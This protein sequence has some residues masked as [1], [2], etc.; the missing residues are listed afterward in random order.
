MQKLYELDEK[1]FLLK[2][3]EAAKEILPVLLSQHPPEYVIDVKKRSSVIYNCVS[4]A[5]DLLNEVG[6]IVKG[7]SKAVPEEDR[8]A[9]RKLED[10][11]KEDQK[12]K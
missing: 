3:L 8:T 12:K 10:I 6:F 1:E 7:A 5:S 4:I 9:I 2:K 11:L